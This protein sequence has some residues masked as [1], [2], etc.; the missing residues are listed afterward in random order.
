[1]DVININLD[2]ARG[3][4]PFPTSVSKYSEPSDIQGPGNIDT[5]RW[6]AYRKAMRLHAGIEEAG[7]FVDL[8]PAGFCDAETLVVAKIDAGRFSEAGKIAMG[9]DQPQ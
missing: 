8:I 1:M 5:I 2:R 6:N 4:F 7:R 3:L 9:N